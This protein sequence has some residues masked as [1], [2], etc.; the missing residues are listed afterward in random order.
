MDLYIRRE[1]A[2]AKV[3]CGM[4]GHTPP[5]TSSSFRSRYVNRCHPAERAHLKSK[6]RIHTVRH[7]LLREPAPPLLS[8]HADAIL[9]ERSWLQGEWASDWDP[10]EAITA[11][12]ALFESFRRL[13][14]GW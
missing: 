13:L 3:D 5:G 4:Y 10:L 11:T 9:D 14:M 6:P 7:Q 1:Y 2:I 12:K 8:R